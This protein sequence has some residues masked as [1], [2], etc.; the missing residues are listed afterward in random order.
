[1]NHELARKAL[2]R[3][4]AI[5]YLGV[6]GMVLVAL[7]FCLAQRAGWEPML[8][9]APIYLTFVAAITYQFAKDL[10]ASKPGRRAADKA[11]DEE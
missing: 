3:R 8:T 1:M 6:L 11:M 7:V 4:L 9:G 5:G 10:R 2:I